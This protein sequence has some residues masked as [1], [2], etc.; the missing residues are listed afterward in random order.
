MADK[1]Q[2]QRLH[3]QWCITYQDG[4]KL[5]QYNEDESTN[6]IVLVDVKRLSWIPLDKPWVQLSNL[7]RRYDYAIEPHQ[8]PIICFRKFIKMGDPSH[9]VRCAYLIGHEE[10]G[11]DGVNTRDIYYIQPP[12]QM[13]K[14]ISGEDGKRVL[15]TYYF[16]GCVERSN[17]KQFNCALDRWQ[18]TIGAMYDET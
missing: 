16:D 6:K 13:K 8:K 15:R 11:V 1:K 17:L 14:I 12:F 7:I 5:W 9:K 4:S 10:K 18:K 2:E 3:F